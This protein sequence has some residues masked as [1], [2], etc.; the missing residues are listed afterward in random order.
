MGQLV[1]PSLRRLELFLSD[2]I[3]PELEF[4]TI[5]KLGRGNLDG[6]PLVAEIQCLWQAG[7]DAAELLL[8]QRSL[9]TSTL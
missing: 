6:R 2:S 1:R 9:P 4:N 3:L 8:N 7:R 5:L